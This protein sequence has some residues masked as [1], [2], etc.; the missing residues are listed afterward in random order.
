MSTESN[1]CRSHARMYRS[2]RRL[3]PCRHRPCDRAH[4]AL[5]RGWVADRGF[6]SEERRRGDAIVFPQLRRRDRPAAVCTPLMPHARS[7]PRAPSPAPPGSAAAGFFVSNPRR[8]QHPLPDLGHA[9]ISPAAPASR[10]FRSTAPSRQTAT[11]RPSRATLGR[12]QS[13]GNRLKLK[14]AMVPAIGETSGRLVRSH[15]IGS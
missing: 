4:R 8:R 2:T 5:H 14:T 7:V 10:P 15:S 12:H 9:V 11:V 3:L 1:R 13:G 6:R